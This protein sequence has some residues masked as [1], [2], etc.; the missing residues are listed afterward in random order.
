MTWKDALGR[1]DVKRC[2]DDVERSCA[3]MMSETARGRPDRH[4]RHCRAAAQRRD[5]AIHPARGQFADTM[6]A[7][8]MPAHDECGYAGLARA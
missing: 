5:P 7:R 4:E 6:D 8:V 2:R 3:R 1:D